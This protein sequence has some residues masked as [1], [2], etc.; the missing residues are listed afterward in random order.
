MARIAGIDIPNDKRVDV[1][2]RY[3]F[4]I[5]PTMA[6]RCLCLGFSQITRTMPRRRMILH[7][8]QRGL[9]DACT[10]TRTLPCYL[11]R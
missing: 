11:N 1:S 5:G 3:I 8:S 10:F 7:L 2:L 6:S 4:G 9:T